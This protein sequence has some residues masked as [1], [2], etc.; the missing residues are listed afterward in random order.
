MQCGERPLEILP[1]ALKTVQAAVDNLRYILQHHFRVVPVVE[2]GDITKVA[3]APPRKEPPC[4]A[5]SPLGQFQQLG[6]RHHVVAAVDLV[7][8]I[9]CTT[10]DLDEATSLETSAV[11]LLRVPEVFPTLILISARKLTGIAHLR[12]LMCY[13]RKE[14]SHALLRVDAKLFHRGIQVV[15]ILVYALVG[16]RRHDFLQFRHEA[17]CR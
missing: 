8:G 3:S 12:T 7:F 9:V 17:Q 6:I 14:V 16:S 10:S 2:V 5:S 13:L 4:A 11:A 15:E 1:S